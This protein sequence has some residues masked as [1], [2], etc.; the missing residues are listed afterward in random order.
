[1]KVVIICALAA[2]TTICAF[3][4]YIN[5]LVAKGF[6][7]FI[8]KKGYTLPSRDEIRACIK[9]VIRARFLR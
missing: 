5:R 9:D 2:S 1:M 6:V 4:W 3:G 8:V 7:W